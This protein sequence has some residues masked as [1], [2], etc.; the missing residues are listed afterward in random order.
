MIWLG[1]PD[2]GVSESLSRHPGFTPLFP[3]SSRLLG[4]PPHTHLSVRPAVPERFRVS[5]SGPGRCSRD[6]QTG[7]RRRSPGAQAGSA[8][9]PGLCCRRLSR[10]A[11]QLDGP[12]LP[13]RPSQFSVESRP[14]SGPIG[15]I[16]F[17][18]PA[19]TR[20]PPLTVQGCWVL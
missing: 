1:L 18:V 19:P 11:S 12:A 13:S 5:C 17:S 3:D 6:R 15:K 10:G 9:S 20:L 7:G 14:C 2:L 4:F 8:T 16:Q